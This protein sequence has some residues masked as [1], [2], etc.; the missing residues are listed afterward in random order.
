MQSGEVRTTAHGKI[1]WLGGYSVLEKPNIG[2]VTTVDAGVNVSIRLAQD[3]SV[4]ID[5]PQFGQRLTGAVD[6]ETGAI[7]ASTTNELRLVKT[8]TQI[9]LMYVRGI[10]NK[11]SG[12]KIRTENDAAFA[13]RLGDGKS[14][15]SKSG[16]GSSAA[17]T[18]ATIGA[19]LTAYGVDLWEDDALHK[20][21]QIAHA[22]ATGMGYRWVSLG[23]LK[24]EIQEAPGSF[25]PMAKDV[26]ESHNRCLRQ[27]RTVDSLRACTLFQSNSSQLPM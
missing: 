21:S 19:I 4:I 9:A 6:I 3:D 5:V 26:A 22:V 27:V 16:L 12:L 18:V 20:I 17:V 10:G 25:T 11:I 13:Y 15:L 2:Y 1:L 14:K 7:N 24:A 8:A 23:N